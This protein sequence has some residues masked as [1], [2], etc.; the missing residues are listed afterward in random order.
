VNTLRFLGYFAILESLL[1]PP[2]PVGQRRL[3]VVQNRAGRQRHL[4][5]T[6]GALP[7]TLPDHVGSPMTAAWANEVLR[8]AT[9]RQ[10]LVAGVLRCELTSEFVQILRKRRARHAPTLRIVAG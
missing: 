5:S 4:M 6:F 10:I 8:P 7:P 3:G 2:K 1:R 9:A